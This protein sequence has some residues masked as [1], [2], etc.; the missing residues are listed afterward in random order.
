MPLP[1]PTN[2]LEQ[3]VEFAGAFAQTMLGTF[4]EFYPFGGALD[5]DGVVTSIEACED[6][7]NPVSQD[8]I[9]RL[10]D[11]V[12]AADRS[13]DPFVATAV[14]YDARVQ[15]RDRDIDSDAVVIEVDQASD[16][17]AVVFMLYRRLG[18]EIHYG[19]VL[20]QPGFGEQYGAQ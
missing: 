11:R 2:A 5:T 1:D 3:L 7:P 4:G 13:G 9:E 12:R 14:V 6:D 20:V 16:E 17:P 18:D 10:R 19:E 8:L 15:I